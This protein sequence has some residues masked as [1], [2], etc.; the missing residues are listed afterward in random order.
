MMK[1]FKWLLLL[2][3]STTLYA[4][5]PYI[6]TGIKAFYPVV[7]INTDKIDPKYKQAILDLIKAQA[8]T[9]DINTKNYSTTSLAVLINYVSVGETIALKVVL[10]VGE[11][12]TRKETHKDVFALSYHASRLFVVENIDEDLMDN[13]EDLLDAFFE[14]YKEDNE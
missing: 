4:Q 9:Y 11:E 6:L 10:V 3:L 5:S 14:Q 2:L 8:K 7:E 1:F 13:V 12:V